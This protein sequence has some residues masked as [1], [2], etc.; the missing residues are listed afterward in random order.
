MT[1]DFC[2]VG[3]PTSQSRLGDTI[4]VGRRGSVNITIEVPGTQGHVAYPQLADNPLP[5]LVALLAEIA[6]LRLDDGTDWFEPSNIE[7]TT[8]DTGNTATN[9]IPG[10]ACARL[11]IRFN[12][13]HRGHDLV[14]RIEAIVR[15]HSDRAIVAARVSGEAFLTLP[16]ALST[17]VGDAVHAVT[18]VTPAL[19]TSGGTSD[20]RFLVAL[21]PTVEFGLPNATMHKLDEGV[22]LVDL[23]ALVDVYAAVI[24]R[25]Y[26]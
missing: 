20:A 4:K 1:P 26:A 22:A 24:A 23:A 2:L 21:C 5:R 13:R 12:D 25:V 3:E 9:V 17:L 16:G 15:R 18:G 6:A 7:L 10:S 8:I 14:A 19:S 11:S